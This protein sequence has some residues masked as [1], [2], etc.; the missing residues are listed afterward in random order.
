MNRRSKVPQVT[1]GRCGGVGQG[2]E[3]S[4]S[5]FDSNPACVF[6]NSWNC[7]VPWASLGMHIEAIRYS[8]CDSAVDRWAGFERD[9]HICGPRAMKSTQYAY[10]SSWERGD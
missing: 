8:S 1:F 3:G 2:V 9:E 10:L 6:K 4:H 7:G 5:L